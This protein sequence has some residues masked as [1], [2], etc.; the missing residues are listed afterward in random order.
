MVGATAVSPVSV[1]EEQE[2]ANSLIGDVSKNER[3]LK[4]KEMRNRLFVDSE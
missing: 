2:G 1:F 3:T 4:M